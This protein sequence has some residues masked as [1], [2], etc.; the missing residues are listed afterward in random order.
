MTAKY[1]SMVVSGLG[2]APLSSSHGSFSLGLVA[3]EHAAG[4]LTVAQ[5]SGSP[6]VGFGAMMPP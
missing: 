2:A 4:W 3:P 6:S 1:L 5:K